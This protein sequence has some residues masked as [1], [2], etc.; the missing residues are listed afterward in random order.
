MVP[1]RDA[2]LCGFRGSF[3]HALW[4]LGTCGPGA[5]RRRLDQGRCRVVAYPPSS[6][7]PRSER[8]R[9]RRV[10]ERSQLRSDA[11]ADSAFRKM[12][13][14]YVRIVKTSLHLTRNFS[15]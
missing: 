12:S 8:E 10:R 14:L 3:V 2:A 4:L 6:N 15:T 9:T 7:S 11:K 5:V 1:H 13:V